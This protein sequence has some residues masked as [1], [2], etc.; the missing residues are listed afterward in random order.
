MARPRPKQSAVMTR[1]Y[2][3]T[4]LV[5]LLTMRDNLDNVS[6]ADVSRMVGLPENECAPALE[7]ERLIRARR[8]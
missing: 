1:E 2:R 8:A 5:Q 7:R 3:R 4:R 6:A